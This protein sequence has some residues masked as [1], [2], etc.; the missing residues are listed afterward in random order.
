MNSKPFFF[1]FVMGRKKYSSSLYK[2]VCLPCLLDRKSDNRFMSEKG[3]GTKLTLCLAHFIISQ[4]KV[5]I[6]IQHIRP[7]QRDVPGARRHNA[8]PSAKSVKSPVS[9]L[10]PL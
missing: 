6:R 2:C 5:Q 3:K 4:L 1:F 7:S 9:I 10:Q 8:R